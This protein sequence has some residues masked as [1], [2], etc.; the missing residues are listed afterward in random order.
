[1]AFRYRFGA[2]FTDFMHL[3]SLTAFVVEVSPFCYGGVD[4]Q[5]GNPDTGDIG[6]LVLSSA[7][8]GHLS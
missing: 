3:G 2:F 6:E 7:V 8:A 5:G 1:M 4:T